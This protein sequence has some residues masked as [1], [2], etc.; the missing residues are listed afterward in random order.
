[1]LYP[2]SRALRYVATLA[3]I[4]G[5][6][7]GVSIALWE[8]VSAV[9]GR[10]PP[11][12]AGGVV[13]RVV[14]RSPGDS[15]SPPLATFSYPIAA[16]VEAREGASVAAIGRSYLPVGV[17]RLKP[18]ALVAFTS[19]N[20]LE[21]LRPPVRAGRLYRAAD[22]ASGGVEC[23]VS[24]SL[25]KTLGG[26]SA[27]GTVLF[28]GTVPCRV[29]GV[30]APGFAGIFPTTASVWMPM[31]PAT[32]TALEPSLL[33]RGRAWLTLYVSARDHNSLR[34]AA[35]RVELALADAYRSVEGRD[36][37][38]EVGVLGL[39]VRD[40]PESER[41]RRIVP[42][43]AVLGI[44]IAFL[45]VATV[46]NAGIARLTEQARGLA[47]RLALGAPR[48]L[49]VAD[50]LRDSSAGVGLGVV[51][52]VAIAP[53]LTR[54]L[55]DT[56]LLDRSLALS[57]TM[58]KIGAAAAIGLG[59]IAGLAALVAGVWHA[60]ARLARSLGGRTPTYGPPQR[61]SI[62]ALVLQAALGAG[63]T[64][65][66]VAAVRGN[67]N[68]AKLDVGADIA[69]TLM[70]EVTP[71]SPTA[72]LGARA[73]AMSAV[74]RVLS[75]DSV[76]K[77]LA[78]AR[79][80]PLRSGWAIGPWSQDVPRDSIVR[81]NEEV[82]YYTP[83]GAGYFT[84]IGTRNLIGRDF[85]P[86][87]DA[88]APRVAIING[89]LAR[90]LYPSGDPVG[91]CMFL[92]NDIQC[93]TVV[94]VLPGTWKLQ[95]LRRSV[96]AVYIP[97]EQ[98][99]HIRSPAPSVARVVFASVAEGRNLTAVRRRIEAALR[100]STDPALT[101]FSVRVETLEELLDPEFT[102][103][104]TT[105]VLLGSLAATA[106]ALAWFGALALAQRT[107]RSR[108]HVL[109]VR[110]ALGASPWRAAVSATGRL[111]AALAAGG[112]MAVV[113][114][115]L[116]QPRVDGAFYQVSVGDAASLLSAVALPLLLGLA[117][118]MQARSAIRAI[119]LG[120]LLRDG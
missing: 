86:S 40:Q 84:T 22:Q 42:A 70:A 97:L 116:V 47:V 106:V 27:V 13:R 54:L 19:P 72:G 91:R 74:M 118:V 111:A 37:P 103:Y 1:V 105:T 6:G 48:G 30:F 63:L 38:L 89:N 95:A 83:V 104:A 120:E 51:L 29:V 32:L 58:W 101:G 18:Q 55:A 90:Q 17:G 52:A 99:K 5:V 81:P 31:S 45:F 28:V 41:Q 26:S 77:Q 76:V 56:L 107:V 82:P 96:R 68:L 102:S 12:G 2:P 43:L 10:T 94:G 15:A 93:V 3:V 79:E 67:R 35:R 100:S 78:T 119:P 92:D 61:L 64:G 7:G 71:E 44:A 65:F 21:I 69:H 113:A 20:G 46:S 62:V 49:F 109:A 34:D 11:I 87:D 60:T 39:A 80:D 98:A 85:G 114:L 25:G 24:D 36:V 23:I 53:A 88:S 110:C 108:R 57:S 16:M 73:D 117:A 8:S 112:G 59:V 115:W 9:A 50:A 75:A 14:L 33:R 4:T 66:A